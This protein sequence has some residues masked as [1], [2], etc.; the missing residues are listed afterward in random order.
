[1]RS[2]S[3]Y[4]TYIITTRRMIS[5]ELLKYQNGL[6]MAASYHV[7]G[8]PKNCSDTTSVSIRVGTCAELSMRLQIH[9]AV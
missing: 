5:G 7:R 6:S 2:D 8:G 3:G 9:T 1:M 4:L